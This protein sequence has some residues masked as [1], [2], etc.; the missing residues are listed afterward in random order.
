MMSHS[1]FANVCL[2]GMSFLN[3]NKVGFHTF[4]R[5]DIFYL[6]FDEEFDEEF[7]EKGKNIYIY[8]YIYIYIP[9]IFSLKLSNF[10]S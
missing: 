7:K 5:E 6:N 10:L 2:I 9:S 1:H 8:I 4:C 3:A